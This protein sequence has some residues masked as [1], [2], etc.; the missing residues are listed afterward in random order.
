MQ[1]NLTSALKYDIIRPMLTDYHNNECQKAQ[2]REQ[3]NFHKNNMILQSLLA[4]MFLT[5]GIYA[6]KRQSILVPIILA[7]SA[8]VSLDKLVQHTAQHRR[9]KQQLKSLE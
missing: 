8:G 2:L 1:A 7:P 9:Y 5:G 4:L 6:A 3:I